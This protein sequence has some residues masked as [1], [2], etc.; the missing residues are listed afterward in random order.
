M[1]FSRQRAF[2]LPYCKQQKLNVTDLISEQL[3][4]VQKYNYNICFM[5]LFTCRPNLNLRNT[6]AYKTCFIVIWR[7]IHT[8]SFKHYYKTRI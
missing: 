2:V 3:Q 5:Y 6:P 1:L 4:F 7:K 8:C